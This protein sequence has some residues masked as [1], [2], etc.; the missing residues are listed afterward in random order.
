VRDL[1]KSGAALVLVLVCV[2]A[3]VAI[4]QS[5]TETYPRVEQ[6]EHSAIASALQR[7]TSTVGTTPAAPQVVTGI[8]TVGTPVVWTLLQNREASGGDNL[9]WTTAIGACPAAAA[10][11]CTG[12]ATD[13][14]LLV[15]GQSS[16]P[17]KWV[18]TGTSAVV[19]CIVG[20]AAGVAYHASS[21][22]VR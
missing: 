1:W 16:D 14:I 22:V 17:I 10:M 4:A 9:C 15:P 11:T 2:V 13:A 12:A 3:G 8:P 18:P 6:S 7:T 19:L 20:S 21:E 5:A